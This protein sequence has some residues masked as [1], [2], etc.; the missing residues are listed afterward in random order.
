MPLQSM[1]LV[2][3]LLDYLYLIFFVPLYCF[4]THLRGFAIILIMLCQISLYI[5]N[6]NLKGKKH[7]CYERPGI[8]SELLSLD[9]NKLSTI[10]RTCSI[11]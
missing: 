11:F 6:E 8:V 7:S 4:Y 3:Y 10:T 9:C 5:Y 2:I 1:I